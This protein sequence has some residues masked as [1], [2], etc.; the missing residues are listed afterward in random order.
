MVD[1]DGLDAA[2][3]IDPK[4]HQNG[5]GMV[6]YGNESLLQAEFYK[7]KKF[8]PASGETV[9]K[10]YLRVQYAPVSKTQMGDI[11]DQPMKETDKYEFP[12][13]WEAFERGESGTLTGTPLNEWRH[14]LVDE[15]LIKELS[16]YNIRTQQ[17]VASIPD[18]ALELLGPQGRFIRDAALDELTKKSE[19]LG[20]EQANERVRVLEDQVQQ[21]LSM[22][23][24][25]K[26]C[27]SVKADVEIQAEEPAKDADV[28]KA[29]K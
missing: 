1:P 23:N 14:P 4:I 7:R 2:R 26:S 20:L 18:T 5:F 21:L 11:Y 29:R 13:A 8:I 25:D 9:E 6:K 27:S 12:L 10:I 15:A 17:Q 19:K 28:K 16:R 22:V 24:S 3:Y